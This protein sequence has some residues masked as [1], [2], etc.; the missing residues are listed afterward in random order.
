MDPSVHCSIKSG[1]ARVTLNRP[2]VHNAFD[3]ALIAELTRV[4]KE[5]SGSGA[6]V[7]VLSGAGS[8]FCAGADLQYMGR[9]AAYSREENISDARRLQQMM[10]AL[11]GLPCVT[12]A[13][14]NGAAMGGGAG[15]AAACDLAVASHGAKFAFSEVRLGLIPAVISPYVIEKIGV[16]AA[17]ALFVTGERFDA[18]TALRLGLVQQ[19]VPPEELDAAVAHKVEQVLHAGPQSVAACKRLLQ[20]LAD[21]SRVDAEQL[22]VECIADLR[23]GAEGQEGIRAF[24]EKRQPGFAQDLASQEGKTRQ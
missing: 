17:R 1:V 6:R 10:A 3:D 22:T 5:V 14:V 11:A 24:L 20:D 23:A 7:M 13:K 16:G 18:E 12:L 15:L 21:L 4:F 9:M 8:S 2:E 19:V